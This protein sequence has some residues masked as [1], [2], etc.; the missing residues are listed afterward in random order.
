MP[1][2]VVKDIM[3]HKY[4]EDKF[5]EVIAPT[6]EPLQSEHTPPPPQAPSY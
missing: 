4:E 6:L 3:S 2:D 1:L 5:L